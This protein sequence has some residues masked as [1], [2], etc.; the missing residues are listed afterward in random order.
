MSLKLKAFGLGL[1][2]M[3]AIGAFA[4]VNA[5]ATTGGHFVSEV[6][7]TEIKGSENAIDRLELTS[8]GLEG[9]TVCDFAAYNGTAN[10][11]TVTEI[12][13]S[14]SYAGCHTTGQAAGTV[15][16]DSFGCKYRFTVAKEAGGN[17]EGT[18]DVVCEAGKAIIVTHPSCEITIAPTNNQNIFGITYTKVA[19]VKHE[20][21]L[22]MKIQVETT[23]HSGICVLT[24]TFHNGTLS[25]AMMLKGT[26]TEG[27]QV[28]I[29]AT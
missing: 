8:H 13:V 24:G 15:K 26:T 1:L 10:A 28:G 6:A 20:I 29:T 19:G 18:T 4:V 27:S 17:V 21:T 11:A 7:H 23:Y 12:E 3:M 2:A 9:G 14:P 5:T 22:D 25:G 16:V